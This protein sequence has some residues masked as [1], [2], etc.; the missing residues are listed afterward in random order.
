MNPIATVLVIAAL[1]LLLFSIERVA[2]LRRR[3]APLVLRL[4]V[5]A[6]MSVLAFATA[7]A[8]VDPVSQWMLQWTSI[9]HFGFASAL[10]LPAAAEFALTFVLLDLTFYYWHVANHRIGFLWR[11]HVA[12]HIDP[13]LD[14]TTAFRFHFAEIALSAGFRVMQIALIGPLAAT[15]ALYEIFFQAGTLFHH[16]N[17]RMP[18]RFERLINFAIVTPR[19]HGIHH[20][21]ERAE[22]NSNFGVVFT[23]WD[24]A[25]RTLRLD[26]AQE[27]IVIGIPGYAAPGD[28]R[29]VRLLALPF[30]RRL[31]R[32]SCDT[33]LG[34]SVP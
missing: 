16:S 10:G 15:Y 21:Q 5:N 14:V 17:V 9:R 12:H 34:H 23:W 8:L 26:V 30:R 4:A 3:S 22:T 33:P 11:I 7:W 19:M 27:R 2:P 6:A 25:H 20:S 13:D 18:M 31:H 32:Q 28:N 1:Y 29:L 24:W